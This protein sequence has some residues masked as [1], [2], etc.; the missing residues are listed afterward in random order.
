VRRVLWLLLA[1]NVAA[2][3]ADTVEMFAHH[4]VW[5]CPAMALG[6]AAGIRCVRLLLLAQPQDRSAEANPPAQS[7]G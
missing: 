1:V 5:L 4:V 6:I 7:T 2:V 3:L